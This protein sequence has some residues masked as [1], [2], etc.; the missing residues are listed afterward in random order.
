MRII[1]KIIVISSLVILI[2]GIALNDLAFIGI[3]ISAIILLYL[4]RKTNKW[5]EVWN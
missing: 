1:D 5:V 2:T 3:G 4:K